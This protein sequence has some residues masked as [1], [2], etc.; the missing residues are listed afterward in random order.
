MNFFIYIKN[1]ATKLIASPIMEGIIRVYNNIMFYLIMILLFV[2]FTYAFYNALHF[3]Y[4]FEN[5]DFLIELV[6]LLSLNLLLYFSLLFGS[7]FIIPVKRIKKDVLIIFITLL[8]FSSLRLALGVVSILDISVLLFLAFM[9]IPLGAFYI[10]LVEQGVLVISEKNVKF[11]ILLFLFCAFFTPLF[12]SVLLW[13]FIYVIISRILNLIRNLQNNLWL[14]LVD[15]TNLKF[16]YLIFLFHICFLEQIG[17]SFGF[18]FITFYFIPFILEVFPQSVLAVDS[19][20]QIR[21]FGKGE[22]NE[23]V[24][25]YRKLAEH[26]R[27]SFVA[28]RLPSF[29]TSFPFKEISEYST[30]I[31]KITAYN[32]YLRVVNFSYHANDVL[33]NT[34]TGSPFRINNSLFVRPL[35]TD[36]RICNEGLHNEITKVLSDADLALLIHHYKY[37][38]INLRAELKLVANGD[39]LFNDQSAEIVDIYSN[40]V[41]RC[42]LELQILDLNPTLVTRIENSFVF[43]RVQNILHIDPTSGHLNYNSAI[44][45][46]G[47]RGVCKYDTGEAFLSVFKREG[48]V[49]RKFLQPKI[50]DV[51]FIADSRQNLEYEVAMSLD[52]FQ[53]KLNSLLIGTDETG[54]IINTQDAQYKRLKTYKGSVTLKYFVEMAL[55]DQNSDNFEILQGKF[56]IAKEL[57]EKE[58]QNE[59][60]TLEVVF[61]IKR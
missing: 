54:Y 46:L 14:A 49:I 12:F 18:Y 60:K 37:F 26:A 33:V 3:G 27:S 2:S 5:L 16:L 40:A 21:T 22:G 17:Y 11:S 48:S 52:A 9:Y 55:Q 34:I 42:Y 20:T 43:H 36:W 7:F 51:A 19:F 1:E 29:F 44:A 47:Q 31:Q 61:N 41:V 24:L 38:K 15:I 45:K 32:K 6:V 25:L 35:I 39:P 50:A 56:S 58:L 4:C 53:I 10:F 57:I 13:L 28:G 59:G 30:N 23:L 8:V